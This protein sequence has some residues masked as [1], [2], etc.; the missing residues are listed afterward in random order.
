MLSQIL[1]GDKTFTIHGQEGVVKIV[2][3]QDL[4]KIVMPEGRQFKAD[5]Y[6]AVRSTIV[7]RQTNS[8][9]ANK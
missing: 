4:L 2:N 8:L 3:N 1:T 7:S 6:V 9:K 5:V